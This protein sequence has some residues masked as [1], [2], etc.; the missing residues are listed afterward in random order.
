MIYNWSFDYE[1]LEAKREKC[2]EWNVQIADCRYR[3]LNQTFD[4]YNSHVKIKRIMTITFIQIGQ[5]H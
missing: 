2:F 4:N 1:E 3:P 5:I